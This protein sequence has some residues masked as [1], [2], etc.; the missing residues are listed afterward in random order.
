MASW[1]SAVS[2]ETLNL[3]IWESYISDTVIE[4][5]T[6][7]TGISIRQ[8]YYDSSDKR[9]EVLSDPGSNIDIAVVSEGGTLLFG[10]SGVLAEIPEGGIATLPDYPDRFRDRC[11]KYAIPYLW[12]TMGIL[13][14]SDKVSEPPQ[15]WSA[16]LS[17]AEYLKGHIA[18]SDDYADGLVPPLISIG[19]S[20]NESDPKVL[21]QA[22]EI[23]KQQAPFVRTYTYIITSVQNPD[24]GQ[25]IY[26][27]LG[28]SGDQ[29][30]LNESVGQPG[31][32]RYALPKEGSQVW[33]DC[34]SITNSSQR[35][36][37]ALQFLKYMASV[38]IAAENSIALRMPPVNSKSIAL[39]PDD[40]RN[41][42]E[43]MSPED[44]IEKSQFGEELPSETVQLRKRIFNTLVN[45]HDSQ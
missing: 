14:R 29:K 21:K 17:P 4:K 18:M 13:Y 6:A 40:M 23:M 42:S 3:L 38:E 27:A 11:S 35:K 2:A 31:L 32:W 5:F 1:S 25:E 7:D 9:D 41:D 16:I 34:L 33:L 12:G 24:F 39:L 45:F 43:L 26:M 10:N 28:Y 36:T 44:R 15:S 19:A 30:T 8:I 20:I 22:F 37:A